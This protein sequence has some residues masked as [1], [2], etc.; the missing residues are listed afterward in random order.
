VPLG[1]PPDAWH[2]DQIEVQSVFAAWCRLQQVPAR[3]TPVVPPEPT[4]LAMADS[5]ALCCEQR[6]THTSPH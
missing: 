2:V 3:P 4:L 5:V 1:G 6:A